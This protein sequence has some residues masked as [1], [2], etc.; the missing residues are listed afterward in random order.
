MLLF[1][2]DS[3]VWI[4]GDSIIT[5]AGQHRDQLG[6]AG[7][8]T[9]K[10]LG[11]SKLAGFLPRLN[12]YL[13]GQPAPDVLVIHLGTNNIFSDE[14]AKVRGRIQECLQGARGLLPNTRVVWSDI[15]PRLYYYGEHNSGGGKRWV[16]NLNRHAHRICRT[17]GNASYINHSV[18]I[19]PQHHNLYRYDGLH[20]SEEGN[21]R[22]RLTLQEA[23]LHFNNNP[24]AP[25][26]PP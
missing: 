22:F 7:V 4:I 13:G 21:I 1:P 20:L 15:L 10:G 12:G 2:V 17:M 14:L 24:A 3:R 18:F 16:V 5:W 19:N 8:V 6:G 9:W 23:L 26:F 25:H 11:G